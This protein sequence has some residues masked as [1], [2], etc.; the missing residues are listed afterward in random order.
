LSTVKNW[1]NKN[2]NNQYLNLELPYSS[3]MW[4]TGENHHNPGKTWISLQFDILILFSLDMYSIVMLLDNMVVQLLIFWRSCILFS[5]LCV[6]SHRQLLF[7]VFF[8]V[9]GIELK[10][11]YMLDKDSINGLYVILIHV[12][13]QFSQYYLLK[14]ILFSFW[15]FCEK[16]IDFS[17]SGFSF[18]LSILLH[19]SICLF[20]CFE[21]R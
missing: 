7:S 20:L 18:G 12:D 8:S 4:V 9:L 19:L 3:I 15:S 11:S 10:V 2:Q 1:A 17:M 5:I 13:V 21:V 6:H 14:R 16:S